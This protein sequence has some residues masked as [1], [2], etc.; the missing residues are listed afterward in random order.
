MS[1]RKLRAKIRAGHS[2]TLDEIVELEKSLG[3]TR[4]HKVWSVND[5]NRATYFILK[6]LEKGYFSTTHQDT[7]HAGQIQIAAKRTSK[8]H[9]LILL[10][11]DIVFAAHACGYH[12][13]YERELIFARLKGIRGLFDE[14]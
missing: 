5:F 10:N 1:T 13:S 9:Q 6:Y 14:C 3:T 8:K 12:V 2:L 11:S 7:V 4:P